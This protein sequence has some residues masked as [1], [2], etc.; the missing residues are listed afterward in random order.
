[1][2]SKKNKY[3]IEVPAGYRQENWGGYLN[4]TCYTYA[5]NVFTDDRLY[6]GD[7]YLDS[8]VDTSCSNEKLIEL[9]IQEVEMFGVNISRCDKDEKVG[10]NEFLICMVREDSVGYYH[11]YRLEEDGFWTHKKPMELPNN[12]GYDGEIIYNPE[13]SVEPGYDVCYY[14]KISK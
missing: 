7:I 10:D 11:F 2:E 3:K 12:I 9:L 5:L 13:E 4:A 6:V 8:R 1:M 14:F